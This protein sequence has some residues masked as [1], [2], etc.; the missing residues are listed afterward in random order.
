MPQTYL[1]VKKKTLEA[2][3]LHLI[4]RSGY[5]FF[6]AIF[7]KK[8]RFLILFRNFLYFNLTYNVKNC[9]INGVKG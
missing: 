1:I 5:P 3:L 8:L 6:Y 7:H 9:I 4:K 2:N